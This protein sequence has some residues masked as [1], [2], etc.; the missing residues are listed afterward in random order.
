MYSNELCFF[1]FCVYVCV[2]C[3]SRYLCMRMYVEVHVGIDVSRCAWIHLH[4]Y[5]CMYVCTH[6]DKWLLTDCSD[7]FAARSGRAYGMDSTR[8]CL[9]HTPCR[10]SHVVQVACRTPR[11]SAGVVMALSHNIIV[12]RCRG[13]RAGYR[14]YV[15][16][17]Y[18]SYHKTQVLAKAA[19]KHA[20]NIAKN[21]LGST[22]RPKTKAKAQ[23][24]TNG[25][26]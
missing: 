20:I 21:G 4:I 22:P 23:K 9:S 15:G 17:K 26:L 19:I 1:L 5:A 10:R 12:V 14:A 3:A 8:L 11:A 7:D 6:A 16:G 24:K 25:C 18:H 13:K 2:V